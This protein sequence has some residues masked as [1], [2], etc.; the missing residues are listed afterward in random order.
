MVATAKA[1]N[2]DGPIG[3][4]R[5]GLL[6]ELL[7]SILFPSFTDATNHKEYQRIRETGKCI[8]NV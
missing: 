8:G 2:I 6:Q 7:L 3:A 4:K 1:Q 5:M